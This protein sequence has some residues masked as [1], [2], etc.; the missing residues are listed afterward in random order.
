MK[1]LKIIAALAATVAMLIIASTNSRGQPEHLTHTDGHYSFEMTTVPKILEHQ[2][3]TIRVHVTGSMDGCPV[4]YLRTSQVGNLA[5]D[6]MH[7][8]T[9][10]QMT[11]Y[12]ADAG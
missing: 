8:F 3:D 12:P 7:R 9:M 2:I 5:P 4:L 1:L 11:R 6:S 10:I